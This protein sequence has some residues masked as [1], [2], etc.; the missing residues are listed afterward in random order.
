[1]KDSNTKEFVSLNG[2][3]HNHNNGNGH[4]N[5]NNNQLLY[6]LLPLINQRPAEE[7]E[8]TLDLRQLWT[9]VKHRLPLIATVAVSF[10]TAVG[11]WT[12][13]RE[14]VYEGKFRLLVEPAQNE[15]PNN[16]IP[17]LGPVAGALDYETQIEVLRSPKVLE[18]IIP[19]ITNQYPDI[20]YDTLVPSKK[21][22]LKITQI[23][24]TKIL[25]ISYKDTDPDKIQ[26]V[27]QQLSQG[28]LRYSL[29][30]RQTEIRQG[31]EYVEDQLPGLRQR[32]NTLQETLQKFRQEHNLISP[33]TE[34][35]KLTERL[36]ALEAQYFE[37]E[38]A[39]N[40][41]Q[42][43]YN[44][45]QQ[46]L[47]I[48]P[49]QALTAS[50]LS[51]SP[52]Y[53][54]L[55]TQLQ[56]VEI[57]LA[58]ESVRFLDNTPTIQAL[59]EERANLLDLLTQEAQIVLGNNLSEELIKSP[60]YTAPSSIRLDLSQKYIGAA[61]N[62][63]VLEIRRQG[64][65]EAIVGIN[66][67]IK[68]LPVLARQY[69]DLSREAN[70][71]TESLNRFLAAQ[72]NLQLEAAQQALP[73]QLIAPAKIPETPVHPKSLRSLALGTIGG[74]FLGLGAAF[75]AERL[76]PIFHSS[77]ELKETVNLPILGLI[78][79]QKELDSVQKVLVSG[80]PSL[81]IGNQKLSFDTSDTQTKEP[82]ENDKGYTSSPFLE[83]FRSFYTNIRLLGSDSL[84]KSLVISSSAPSEGKSTIS[85]NLAKAASA[86]G[87]KVLL[88]DADLRRPQVHHRLGVEN[89]K[90]LSN[91]I[92]MN[93]DWRSVVKSVP[94][95]EN[96]SVITAGDIPPDPTRLLSSQRMQEVMTELEN[97]GDFDLVIYDTP[98]LLGFADARILAAKT[99]GIILV[100]KIGKT[101][102]SAFKQ[103]IEQ[104]KMSHVSLLGVVA[105]NVTRHSHGSYYY[106]DH[107]NKYYGRKS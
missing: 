93:S 86:M 62:L 84:I 35:Q 102:R 17:I 27:L 81:S 89:Q 28:Y 92:A 38:V 56:D 1:M 40:E 78:P 55:L 90:G 76:D 30:E 71:A 6:S 7:E 91:V 46:Q 82:K 9:V 31:I 77:E 19:E 42:S 23:D 79:L 34:G 16:Q 12:I 68:L 88:I 107:H 58:Q 25:E 43:L 105:N 36:I 53:Q 45:L 101:D 32:V 22:P 54:K 106:Y 11:L 60:I 63:K 2:N 47:G 50:Y 52:H 104:L 4:N 13:T 44:L 97:C 83:A 14:P 75:L 103:S 85:L 20:A 59:K 18:P 61:N 98:P 80:L 66:A 87:Q 94:H 49:E 24:D 48:Q 67:D 99:T 29:Y 37:A 74:L 95:W 39:F 33:E 64:I 51:E 73:W 70:V 96:I 21:P 15:S 100:A 69:T 72:E 5:Y 57:K 8:P 3:G 10:T 26:F 65:A 41:T